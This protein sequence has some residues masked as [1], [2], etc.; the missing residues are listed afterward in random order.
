MATGHNDWGTAEEF[1]D[2]W[3]VTDHLGNV[4]AVVNLVLDQND[5]C[6][7]GARVDDERMEVDGEKR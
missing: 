2:T 5:Y 1:I 4:R 7:F 3:H 6:P